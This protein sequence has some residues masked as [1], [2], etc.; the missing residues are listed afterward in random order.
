MKRARVFFGTVT[1]ASLAGSYACSSTATTGGLGYDECEPAPGLCGSFDAS[2]LNDDSGRPD[3]APLNDASV[4]TDGSRLPVDDGGFFN[5]DF[6]VSILGNV[7]SAGAGF[8]TPASQ[9]DSC[10]VVNAGDC[11]LF[12]CAVGQTHEY[13][14][15]SANPGTL[16][17]AGGAPNEVVPLTLQQDHA[18]EGFAFDASVFAPATTITFRATGDVVPAFTQTLTLPSL[19][20]LSSPVTSSGM[21]TIDRGSDF[22]VTW[23]GGSADVV[24]VAILGTGSPKQI[25][26]EF[27]SAASSGVVPSVLLTHLASGS[28][29]ISFL[30]YASVITSEG[31]YVVRFQAGNLL[32]AGEATATLK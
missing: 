17:V 10:P 1:I 24:G 29:Q 5:S 28:A 32:D 18:Y 20:T 2:G 4:A 25:A 14:I 3:G 8:S 7:V 15:D 27:P 11:I 31:A 22:Q 16:T 6:T 9:P 21:I 26:C 23:S 30:A 13:A 12:D 19:P